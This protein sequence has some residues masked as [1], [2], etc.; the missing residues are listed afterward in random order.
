MQGY[1]I[2]F[3]I[4]QVIGSTFLTWLV[5]LC[6]TKFSSVKAFKMLKKPI[7]IAAIFML[8][9]LGLLATVI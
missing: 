2:G 6:F 8:T 3:L 9:T 7:C 4:G 5:C 1:K